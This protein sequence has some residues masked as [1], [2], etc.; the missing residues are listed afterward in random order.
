MRTN[1]PKKEGCS[2]G[3]MIRPLSVRGCGGNGDGKRNYRARHLLL[4]REKK[5]GMCGSR[6]E[7]LESG[8]P[9]EK[10]AGYYLTS[11]RIQTENGFLSLIGK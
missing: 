2:A 1:R 7:F 9:G 5:T 10:P 8:G 11:Y 6:E 4:T 3:F